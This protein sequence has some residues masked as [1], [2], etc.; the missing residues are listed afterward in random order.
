MKFTKILAGI[1]LAVGLIGSASANTNC[2]SK[3]YGFWIDT[4]GSG[5][6]SV[7]DTYVTLTTG[8][9]F[10]LTYGTDAYKAA[11]SILQLQFAMQQPAS[12]IFSTD[13]VSCTANS[14]IRTD[15]YGV[16]VSAPA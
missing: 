13:G 8:V 9:I 15:F 4:S 6:G 16:G 2:A 10:K 3:I 7:G 5:G 14:P 11:I 1:A 12:I